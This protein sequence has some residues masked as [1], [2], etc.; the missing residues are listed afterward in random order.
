M[1][2]VWLN[3]VPNQDLWIM[4]DSLYKTNLLN[5]AGAEVLSIKESSVESLH[6]VLKNAHFVIDDTDSSYDDSPMDEFEKNYKYDENSKKNVNFIMKRN[7]LRNDGARSSNNISSWDEDYLVYPH[8]LLVD[9]I[10]WFHPKLPIDKYFRFEIGNNVYDHHYWFRNIATESPIHMTSN[11]KCPTE[12][13]DILTQN[14]CINIEN[15]HIN[16]INR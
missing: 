13:P 7:I 15:L 4:N 10:Y 14:I 1:R 9:L 2:V 11:T 12:M 8:L 6:E 3:K 5:D 16:C